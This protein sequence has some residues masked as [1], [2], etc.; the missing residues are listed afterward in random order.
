MTGHMAGHMI[1]VALA[2]PLIALGLSGTSA[3][4]ARRWPRV[5]TPLT[6]ML[7]E[8]ATVWVWH[9]PLL[10]AAAHGSFLLMALEQA[11]FLIAG[12]LL[13]TSAIHGS[14]RVAGVGALLLTS[15]HMTLLGVLVG[16]ASR[17]LYPALHHGG[18]HGL[19]ALTD[20]QVGGVVMLLIGGVSYMLGGLALLASVIRDRREVIP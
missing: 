18:R 6:M 4:L 17:P 9:L 16:L 20:Q 7:V 3:D 14:Q 11:S 5:I 12:L 15:M 19:D 8:L 13:W 1:A 10:R 2:A